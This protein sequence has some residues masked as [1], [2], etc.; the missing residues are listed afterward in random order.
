MKKHK[1][2]Y[3]WPL[4]GNRQISEYLEK[5]IKNNSVKGTYI[6]YGPDNLGK[7]TVATAFAR[8]LLCDNLFQKSGNL[9]C[10]I[11]KS[12]SSFNAEEEENEI[13]HGDFTVV[14]PEV[15][16]KNISVTQIREFIKKLSMS[17]FLG[18]YKVGVIKHADRLS[19]E[20]ANALLKTL[21]EPREKVVIVLVANSLDHLPATIVSRSQT[22]RFRNV[23]SDEIYDF[24]IKKKNTSREMAKKFAQL[25][26]GRPALAVKFL[27][28]KEYREKYDDFVRIFLSL[29]TRDVN[30]QFAEIGK[31]FSSRS[32]NQEN[33]RLARRILEIWQGIARDWIMHSYNNNDLIQHEHAVK[34]LNLL[35]IKLDRQTIIG[36]IKRFKQAEVY[37]ATNVNPRL[38]LE[39]VALHV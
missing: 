17:S 25:S 15:D 16:K 18:S 33:A 9:P 20:A 2:T 34:E 35:D 28:D 26:M 8:D 13:V 7:S 23:K 3:S 39:S 5:S 11:C 10:K 12:C 32:S 19:E 1:F 24:L 21:E 6:F 38:V 14:K 36:L 29:F 30:T 22:L 37:I 4:V 27:E 31:I